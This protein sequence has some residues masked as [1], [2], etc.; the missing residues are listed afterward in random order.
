[1]EAS[2]YVKFDNIQELRK[3]LRN[4]AIEI[5]LGCKEFDNDKDTK[6]RIQKEDELKIF[7]EKFSN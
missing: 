7:E 1:M 5:E 6:F 2:I 3:L 4:I